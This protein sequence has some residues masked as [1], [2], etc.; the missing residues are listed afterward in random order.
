MSNPLISVCIPSYK[1][2]EF[3]SS[4][5]DSILS[6]DFDSY[7]IIICEDNSPQRDEIA[8]T[9][10]EQYARNEHIKLYLNEKN[11]GY[12]AN[13]RE[14]LARS[15]GDYCF[16]M[17]NDDVMA[18]GALKKVAQ[19]VRTQSNIGLILRS[20]SWFVE[21]PFKPVQTV[22]Y[23][24]ED[25][26]FPPGA[27]TIATAY[28][29]CGV[30]SGYVIRREA[31]ISYATNIFDGFLYYQMYLAA[32]VL[33]TKCAYY[34]HDV[35]TFSRS[36]EA[37]DFGN[38]KKEEG[39]FTPG[40]YTP[41]ARIHMVTGMLTIARSVEKKTGVHFAHGVENDIANYVYPYISDQLNLP[42]GKYLNLYRSLGNLGLKKY[43]MFHTHII[44]AYILK[45]KGYNALTKIIRDR[46]GRSPAIGNIYAGE[47][48]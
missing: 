12:D 22:R 29:R 17:G 33:T 26:I 36:T 30:L 47:K 11:L 40:G 37:P 46:L 9:I 7:E 4:L 28:R 31:A 6:Q 13:F 2:V 48:V 18:P 25:R 5:L 35:L 45:E 15:T 34:V 3:L 14:L 16:F 38:S 27:E 10:H 8:K 1:R 24:N 44:L 43:K 20:Y 23:F 32:C 41:E 39:V 42:L 21:D 19:V